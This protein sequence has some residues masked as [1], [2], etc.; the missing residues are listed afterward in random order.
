MKRTDTLIDFLI[1]AFFTLALST[2]GGLVAHADPLP[3]KVVVNGQECRVR[4]VCPEAHPKPRPKPKAVVAPVQL[5][6]IAP[7]PIVLEPM[8]IS[9]INVWPSEVPPPTIEVPVEAAPPVAGN[10]VPYV[11]GADVEVGA[12]GGYLGGGVTGNGG[13]Y[14]PHRGQPGRNVGHTSA[15]EIDPASSVTAITA[16]LLGLAILGSRYK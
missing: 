9:F 4:T 15:P 1:F 16:L 2:V 12:G 7:A 3:N 5:P 6:C 10:D 14:V 8:P 11:A 13:G